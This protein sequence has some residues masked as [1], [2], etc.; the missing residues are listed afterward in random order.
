[1]KVI[2][3]SHPNGAAHPFKYLTLCGVMSRFGS[4][5]TDERAVTCKKCK[6]ILE[7]LCPTCMGT[8]VQ[9]VN[10]KRGKV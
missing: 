3:E 9:D 10:I 7:T 2:H 1:M 5:K 6:K 4:I 8:G